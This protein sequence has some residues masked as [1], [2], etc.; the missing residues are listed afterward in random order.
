MGRASSSWRRASRRTPSTCAAAA[1]PSGERFYV[2]KF[3]DYVSD[4]ET[5]VRLRDRA[6][7]ASRCSCSA[8]APAASSP[9]IYTLEHQADLAGFICESFAFQVPA[10]DFALAVLKGLSHV[11]P[12]A[13][14]CS[15]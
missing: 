1:A 11:A 14:T 5:V 9:C 8:T 3:S 15:S 2:E 4:V 13:A 12:H 7:G 6:S 10:P